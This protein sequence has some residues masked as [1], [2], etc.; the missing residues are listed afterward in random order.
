[1]YS[2]WRGRR[3]A[4][5]I[6][7][8]GLVLFALTFTIFQLM[9]GAILSDRLSFNQG[10]E[11][12]RGSHTNQDFLPRW[13]KGHARKMD[14]EVEVANRAVEVLEWS[15]ERKVFSV[16]PGQGT[17]VRLKTYYYPYWL[18][19]ANNQKLTT[20]RAD[21]GALMVR[22]PAEKTTVEVRFTEPMSSYIAG[23]VSVVT[24]LM[25]VLLLVLPRRSFNRESENLLEP[26]DHP[27]CHSSGALVPLEDSHS[28]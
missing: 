6:A 23:S 27:A 3:R 19:F 28:P 13:V 26:T 12:L 15:A 16:E 5:S 25:I 4:L 2:I 18:A 11:L 1:M 21:D 17:D 10:V 24:L 22:V 20:V 8:T 9:R 14:A 7:F